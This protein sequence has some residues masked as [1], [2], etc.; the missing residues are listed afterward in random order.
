MKKSVM[1]LV[2]FLGSI[3]NFTSNA[4]A[5]GNIIKVN[6]LSPIAR[7]GNFSYE[8]VIGE[9]STIQMGV[10]YTSMKYAGDG[11]SGLAITPEYRYYAKAAGEGFY[12]APYARYWDLKVS[13]EESSLDTKAKVG[14]SLLSVGVNAGTQMAVGKRLKVDLFI[15]PQY[16]S[17]I[18]TSA[19]VS[20]G[21][22]S[23]KVSDIGFLGGGLWLR[24]GMN[25]GL[26]F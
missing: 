14:V 10:F 9:K 3:L 15:G 4:V 12:I 24:A 16:I 19:S 21:G 25:F 7:T 8:R 23:E 22:D 1:I 17:T 11:F 18:K 2:L 6:P 5:Q 26:A 13:V 20:A